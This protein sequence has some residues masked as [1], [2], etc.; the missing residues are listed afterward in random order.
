MLSE[1]LTEDVFAKG[2][3]VSHSVVLTN[4]TLYILFMI[5]LNS[6]HCFSPKELSQSVCIWKLCAFRSLGPSSKSTL[7]Q[8][9]VC[10]VNARTMH[11]LIYKCT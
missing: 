5:R 11:F 1:F 4:F 6:L 10:M 9:T 2:L 3:G 8:F 7:L